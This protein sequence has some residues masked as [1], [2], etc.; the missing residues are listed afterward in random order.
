MRCNIMISMY[1]LVCIIKSIIKWYYH[2][3]IPIV[4]YLYVL[5]EKERKSVYNDANYDMIVYIL[6]VLITLISDRKSPILAT[7]SGLCWNIFTIISL[8]SILSILSK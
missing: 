2:E 5:Q 7:I 1:N 4:Y 6:L 3:H 8:L